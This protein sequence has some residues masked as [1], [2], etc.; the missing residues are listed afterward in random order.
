MVAISVSS[1]KCAKRV[2]PTSALYRTPSS[3]D[4]EELPVVGCRGACVPEVTPPPELQDRP[5]HLIGPSEEHVE[6]RSGVQR[7]NKHRSTYHEVS[8]DPDV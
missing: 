1:L 7:N 3:I 8:N 6:K 2:W 4:H 5:R